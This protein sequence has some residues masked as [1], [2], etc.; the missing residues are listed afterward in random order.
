MNITTK[1]RGKRFFTGCKPRITRLGEKFPI[2]GG[3]GTNTPDPM[4]D[5]ELAEYADN[6]MLSYHWHT[7]NQ[8]HQGTCCIC[9]G[10]GA[11][12]LCRE[13]MGLE[14]VIL[15]QGSLYAFDYIDSRGN[16]VPRRSD[17]GQAIDTCLELFREVGACPTSVIDQ[18]DWKGY[19]RGTWPSDWRET[20]KKYR[21]LEA[22]DVPSARHGLTAVALGYGFIYGLRSHAVVHISQEDDLNSWGYDWGTDGIGKWAESM[23]DLDN[24]ISQY[25]GWAV[26]LSVDPSNDSDV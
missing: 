1:I 8:A 9:A 3:V 7:I 19:S 5:A 13:Q 22:W 17:N 18:Y 24:G 21:I 6:S 26:R 11:V 10:C 20:A 15:S 2:F 16:L 4:T 25:G 14:R 23:Q 12:M